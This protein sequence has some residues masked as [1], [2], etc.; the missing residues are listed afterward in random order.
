MFVKS[1]SCC[2]S[3]PLLKFGEPCWRLHCL[4]P[5]HNVRAGNLCNE[6]IL[7]EQVGSRYLLATIL[8]HRRSAGQAGDMLSALQMPLMT[9]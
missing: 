7:S 2:H 3:L 8:H 6:G 5:A 1:Q 9:W 4:L